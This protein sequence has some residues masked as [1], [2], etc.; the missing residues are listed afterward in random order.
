MEITANVRKELLEPVS[1]TM[2]KI[3]NKKLLVFLFILNIENLL[4]CLNQWFSRQTVLKNEILDVNIVIDIQDILMKQG[5][6]TKKTYSMWHH[7]YIEMTDRSKHS[8]HSSFSRAIT[9]KYTQKCFQ[10][11]KVTIS[12]SFLFENIQYFLY[13]LFEYSL[14][15][16]KNI[17][18]FQI[19]TPNRI[20]ILFT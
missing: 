1:V 6:K 19:S 12:Q 4:V 3:V 17:F 2:W 8:I 10:G 13:F 18:F 11:L 16:I 14:F 7:V 9:A 5:I 20:L 15:F